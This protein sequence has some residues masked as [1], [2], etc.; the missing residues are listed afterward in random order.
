M[1]DQ[2]EQAI[3]AAAESGAPP[4]VFHVGPDA[5]VDFGTGNGHPFDGVT[6]TAWV[7]SFD[8]ADVA[9]GRSE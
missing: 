1:H 6:L 7:D 2:L 4:K 8:A 5:A 9:T 3:L